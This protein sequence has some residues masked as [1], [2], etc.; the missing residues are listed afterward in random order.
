M[1]SDMELITW[2]FQRNADLTIYPISDVHLGAAEH[3]AAR[4]EY[5]CARVLRENNSY[6]ILG[7]DLL[8][9]GVKTSISNCY[10]ETLPPMAAR[11]LL[12]E[13]LEPLADR[14]LCMVSGNHERRNRD[15][16]NS[17]SYDIARILGIE[18]VYRENTAFMKLQIGDI[19]CAGNRNPTY[20]FCTT[21][22]AGTGTAKAERFAYSLENVDCFVSGHT[23]KPSVTQ[24]AKIRVDTHNNRVS[25]RPFKMVTMTSWLAWGGYAAQ[26]MYTPTSWAPQ[27]IVLNG[28]KK[29]IKVE[30]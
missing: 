18:K 24:P 14:I 7:G 5:F 11:E 27:K 4:W 26:A 19:D 13:M 16:D 10:L 30:M 28:K 3:M 1:L 22:G 23:H 17:P 21:H 25:I 2:H 15:V 29:E 8:N 20:V 12:C 6:L 9:N